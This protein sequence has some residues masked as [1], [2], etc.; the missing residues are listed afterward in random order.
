MPPLNQKAGAVDKQ[1][2]GDHHSKKGEPLIN[3]GQLAGRPDHPD[4]QAPDRPDKK[5]RDIPELLETV[6]H[7]HYNIL[8]KKSGNPPSNFAVYT[9]LAFIAFFKDDPDQ[10]LQRIKYVGTVS[11]KS[12]EQQHMFRIATPGQKKIE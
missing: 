7:D 8:R 10:V 2:P 1:K 12:I 4:K 9:K 6:L 11:K 5:K 3:G